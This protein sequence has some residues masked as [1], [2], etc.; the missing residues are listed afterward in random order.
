[1][2]LEVFQFCALT[3]L[4]SSNYIQHEDIFKKV[5]QSLGLEFTIDVVKYI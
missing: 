1:M 3:D 4:P 2:V 5:H